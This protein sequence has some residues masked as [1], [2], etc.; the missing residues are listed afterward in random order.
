MAYQRPP[1][2]TPF[3][4]FALQNPM[5]I[6][7][8]FFN[9]GPPLNARPLLQGFGNPAFRL[10]PQLRPQM[11]INIQQQQPRPQAPVK[12]RVTAPPKTTVFVGN[13]SEEVETELLQKMCDECGI[14]N[15]FRRLQGANGKPQA[16]GFCEYNHPD[17][18]RRA[19]RLLNGF[20]FG[21]KP[22]L[23]KVEEK[24]M[25][26]IH[27]YLNSLRQENGLSLLPLGTEFPIS[28]EERDG[29]IIAKRRIIEMIEAVDKNL[30]REPDPLPPEE[31]KK[32]EKK[33]LSS[34]ES[35]DD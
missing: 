25:N 24:V 32:E 12:F 18:T 28:D 2:R 3:S 17:G 22:L 23:I 15:S 6:P 21:G 14:V 29:D 8:Q 4:A 10:P 30:L 13:I 35:E 27:E 16:F 7:G 33:V 31:P 11:P 20:N 9:T 26:Q 19:L 1:F 34:S 5:P